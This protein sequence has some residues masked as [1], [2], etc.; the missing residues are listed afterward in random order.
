MLE[1]FRET[2]RDLPE[3][4]AIRG[5]GL[6]MGIALD[7]PCGK[8]MQHALEEKLLINVTAGN[9][10]RLLPPLI[11]SDREAD[12]IVAKVNKLIRTFIKES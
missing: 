6:M 12:T 8:L 5:Q 10:I 11:I 2:L 7:R 4:Q 9:V 3:I 1:A